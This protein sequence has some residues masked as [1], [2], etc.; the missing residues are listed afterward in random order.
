[1]AYGVIRTKAR[2]YAPY[3]MIRSPVLF[4]ALGGLGFKGDRMRVEELRKAARQILDAAVRAVDP[5]EAI[6]RRVTREGA[7]LRVGEDTLDMDE[8]RQIVV[9]GCG[10]AAAPMAAAVEGLLG[11]RISRGVVVTKYGH[12]QPT[13]MIRIHQA[14]HPVPDDAG[15]LGAQAILDTSAASGPGIRFWFSSRVAARP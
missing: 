1:V 6:R 9:V 14:G 4:G 8:V 2:L 7:R 15:R 10:K 3:A 13:R 12:V 11:D 5:G